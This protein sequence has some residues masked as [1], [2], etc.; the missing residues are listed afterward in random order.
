MK[1]KRLA[2]SV[3]LLFF[4]ASACAHEFDP[5]YLSL[6]ESS[7]GVFQTQWKASIEGG[8]YQ[9]MAPRLPAECSLDS[10]LRTYVVLDAQIQ[11]TEL[12]CENGLANRTIEIGGLSSTMT[13]VLLRIDYLDGSTFLHRLTPGSPRVVAPETADSWDVIATYLILGVE[14]ILLG[15]DHLLFVLALLLLIS[16]V[17]RLILTITAFTVAH[18]VTLAA[19]TLGWLALPAAPV[20]AT[21]ALSILFLATQLGREQGAGRTVDATDDLT[22]RFPWI[23]AFSFGLLHGFGFAGALADIGLPEQAIPL[24]LLFFNLGV[25][26][27]QLLFIAAVLSLGGLIRSISLTVPGWWAR[28]V[29]YGIG[30]VAAFWVYERTAWLVP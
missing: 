18:S 26:L 8:L 13:D 6:S 20:E 12:T 27:G 5:G 4:G 3:L 19:T 21:I 24:A 17:K 23:V 11:N 10:Q 15:I 7:A 9:A 1:A 30:S 28:A 29:A 14:H 2:G 25:E 16:G 22:A